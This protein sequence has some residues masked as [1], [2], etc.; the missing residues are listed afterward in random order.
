M[1]AD[2]AEC[3]GCSA[4]TVVCPEKCIT[5]REDADGFI[6][7]LV[8]DGAC[9]HC[10][11]CRRVCPALCPPPVSE[12]LKSW[13]GWSTDETLR[14]Q[15]SSGGL[16]AAVAQSV[17]AVGGIVYGAAF[18]ANEHSVAH[19]STAA[20]GLDRLQRSKYVQ[21]DIS[22]SFSEIQADL[23]MGRMVLFC[24][25]P[26]QV[27]GLHNLVGRPENLL[28]CD[29]SCH[30]VPSRRIFQDYLFS[31]ETKLASRVRDINFRSKINGWE[32]STIVVTFEDGSSYQKTNSIDPYYRG[33]LE[34][35]YLNQCC[36]TCPH[37]A[38]HSSDLVLADYWRYAQF[39]PDLDARNGISLVIAN[40]PKGLA[41]VEALR[42]RVFLKEV[43]SKLSQYCFG[44][45]G[46]IR[47]EGMARCR[48]FLADYRKFGYANAMR[49]HV[50]LG[51]ISMLRRRMDRVIKLGVGHWLASKLK[52]RK[53]I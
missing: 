22:D 12:P 6:K 1:I 28:T 15:S 27:N 29:F 51:P 52:G 9:I 10:G 38:R 46:H 53:T 4:C 40:T 41:R 25:T 18:F 19:S 8:A 20:L 47:T 26:C 13:C 48:R 21:S 5:M 2:V 32:R 34:G 24:G 44:K 3:V 43:P 30:G 45:I 11:K 16:Y 37:N 7:P 14:L 50:R 17:Q 39:Q 35:L 31:L 33:F 36:Y 49:R 42:D 23:R